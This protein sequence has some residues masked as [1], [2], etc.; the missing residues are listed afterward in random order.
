MAKR[1]KKDETIKTALEAISSLDKSLSE[2]SQDPIYKTKYVK[3]S[4]WVE[5]AK[6]TVDLFLPKLKLLK[7]RLE[8][9]L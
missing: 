7:K 1:K 9:I 8:M 5:S 3:E 4:E 2:I 6:S